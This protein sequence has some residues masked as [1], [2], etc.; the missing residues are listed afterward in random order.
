MYAFRDQT[1][2]SLGLE[3]I[4]HAN[5]ECVGAGHQPVRPRLGR[6]HRHHED[7]GPQAGARRAR[8]RRRLRR[9]PPRRGALAGEGA[10]VL[11]PQRQP[12]LGPQEPAARA[13]AA[14]QR[15]QAR[16]ARSIRV[17]PLCNWTEL[18]IWLY[19][20]REQIPIVP[21]YFARRAP[22]RRARRDADHGRRR[23]PSAR[24]RRAAGDAQGALPHARLL[25]ADRRDRERRRTRC[26][27]SS[28]RCCS[29]RTSERRAG[30]RPRPARIDGDA[31][32]R[33]ATS[34][35]RIEKAAPRHRRVPRAAQGQDAAALHHLRQRRRRQEHADRSPALRVAD[36]LRGPARGAGG[37]LAPG[38]DAG[39]R[40]RPRA[41]ARRPRRRARAGHHDRRRL[42]IL[43][44]RPAHVHRRR[45]A[46]PRAVHAQHGHRRLDRRLRRRAGRR[47][48]GHARP[49][50][51]GTRCLARCSAS[52]T[53]SSQSTRWTS[54][55]T[56]RRLRRDRRELPATTP[57]TSA[58]TT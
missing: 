30:D 9:R 47:P 35:G 24:A 51:A 53:W 13:L 36:D 15:V 19:I 37:R 2:A 33:R 39:R 8:L 6:P 17:F 16:P 18:D 42:P 11:V 28:R 52:A 46:R 41:A 45:H 4:V 14:L 5:Q 27:R 12:P 44:D 32:S 54:S 49:R 26:R 10:R 21:L 40:A 20:Y 1:V 3:L 50:P 38:R 56:T 48:Q 55:T 23:A 57:P 7:R 22:G 25:P 31:R 29:A 58:S 43:L 34:N